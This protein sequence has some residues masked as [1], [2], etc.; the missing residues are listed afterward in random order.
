MAFT[1]GPS[2]L[3]QIRIDQPFDDDFGVGRH[4]EID[5][6]GS[7]HPDRSAG[8]PA[9]DGHSSRSTASFMPPMNITTRAR[10]M[11][12]A[13]GIGSPTLV[14]LLPDADAAA[15]AADARRIG[16]SSITFNAPR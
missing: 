9:G 16:T 11:T 1:E 6:D 14:V 10:P 3:E 13:H 15:S 4:V 2:R 5:G 7:C 12:M 8:E